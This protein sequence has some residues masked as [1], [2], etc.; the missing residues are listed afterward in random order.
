VSSVVLGLVLIACGGATGS[1]DQTTTTV[2]T[3]STTTTTAGQT[4]TGTDGAPSADCLQLTT[5][6]SEAATLG[7]GS[8][9]GDA[10]DTVQALQ[11]M[12]AVAPAE[13]ADDLSVLAGAYGEFLS[14]LEDAGV[15]FADPSTFTSPEAQAALAAAS[16]T[17]DAAG[18]AEA[19]ANISAYI[20]SVCD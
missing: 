10:T 16:Q 7:L 15:D 5:T 13:I 18:V 6:L 9:A 2:L 12:A 8:P 4:N 3:E 1:S 20:D 17:L 14:A 19:S 11:D